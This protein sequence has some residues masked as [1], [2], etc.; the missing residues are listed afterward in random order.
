MAG[1]FSRRLLPG[2]LAAAGAVL[3]GSSIPAFEPHV[4]VVTREPARRE[5]RFLLFHNDIAFLLCLDLTG[6]G[7]EDVSTISREAKGTFLGGRYK[8]RQKHE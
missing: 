6:L 7:M 8:F 2:L 1:P 3:A 4:F 5:D